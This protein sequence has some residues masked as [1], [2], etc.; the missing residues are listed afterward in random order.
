[1]NALRVDGPLGGEP[2]SALMLAAANGHVEIVKCLLEHGA[3][4]D[5]QD[6]YERTALI[7]AVKGGHTQVVRELLNRGADVHIRNVNGDT[8]LWYASYRSDVEIARM[9]IEK[10]PGLIPSAIDIAAIPL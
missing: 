7:W 9:L 5:I 8:A 2:P 3:E 10:G 4:P 1:M 6:S